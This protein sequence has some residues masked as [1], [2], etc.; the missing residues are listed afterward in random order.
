[1]KQGN[2]I[3]YYWQKNN[4]MISLL[5]ILFILPNL[6]SLINITTPWGFKIHF[7]QLAIF[8]AAIFYGPRGGLLAG[9]LGSILPA[10]L[11]HNPYVI[12]GNMILG[13]LVGLFVNRGF[14][15]IWAAFLAYSLELPWLIFTDYYLVHLPVPAIEKIIITLAVSN[16]I[17]A[18]CTHYLTP[19]IKNWAHNIS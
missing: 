15:I 16:T 6:L 11:A 4:K 9:A 12:I 8:I 14:P 13:F 3:V 10:F 17:W 1:M 18:I 19:S 7:F 2:A 5:I